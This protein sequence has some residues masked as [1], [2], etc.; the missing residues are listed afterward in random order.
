MRKAA[1]QQRRTFNCDQLFSAGTSV[2]PDYRAYCRARS[3][4]EFVAKMGIVE[5]ES[6][7]LVFWME[8]MQEMDILQHKSVDDKKRGGRNSGHGYCFHK[9]RKKENLKIWVK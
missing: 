9:N 3:T 4:K 7:V 6:D 5:E 2:R 8:I 1:F